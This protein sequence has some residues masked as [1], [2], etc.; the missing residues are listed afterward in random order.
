MSQF[1]PELS[2]N[3]SGARLFKQHHHESNQNKH[4]SLKYGGCVGIRFLSGRKLS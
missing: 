2:L 1:W 3:Y 4:K